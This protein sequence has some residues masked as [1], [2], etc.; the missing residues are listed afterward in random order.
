VSI[1]RRLRASVALIHVATGAFTFSSCRERVL[2]GVDVCVVEE[3]ETRKKTLWLA[4]LGPANPRKV[5]TR[6]RKEHV[7]R[8]AMEPKSKKK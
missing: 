7:R 3:R 2:L 5:S 6:G 8:G 4:F 1:T